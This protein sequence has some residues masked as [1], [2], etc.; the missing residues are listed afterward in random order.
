MQEQ[1]LIWLTRCTL[2]IKAVRL[3][4]IYQGT[5]KNKTKTGDVLCKMLRWTHMQ[6]L[7]QHN[8]QLA[9]TVLENGNVPLIVNAVDRWLHIRK[10]VTRG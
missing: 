7:R 9:E 4:R 3:Y 6:W 1:K 10:T 8:T 5:N 2:F